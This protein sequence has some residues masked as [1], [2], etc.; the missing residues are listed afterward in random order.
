MRLVPS[1][2]GLREYGGLGE[3]MA[4]REPNA[5]QADAILH[6]GGALFVSAGAGSGKTYVLSRRAARLMLAAGGGSSAFDRVLVITFTEKA[7]GEILERI[8]R[9]LTEAR[10]SEAARAA[11]SAWV[12]TIHGFCLRVL[13]R[14]ALE[15]GVD[16]GFTVAAEEEAWALRRGAFEQAAREGLHSDQDL[17]RL[18]EDYGLDRAAPAFMKALEAVRAMGLAPGDV[19]LPSDPSTRGYAEAF[20]RLLAVY[21]EEYARAKRERAVVDYEDM[22]LLTARLFEGRPDIA[23]QYAKHFNEVM[24]DEFQ[25]TNA[26]QMRAVGPVAGE[27]LCTVGDECQAIY[28][29]RHADVGMF[30]SHREAAEVGGAHNSALSV[31][32]RSHPDILAFVNR[33]FSKSRLFGERFLQLQAGSDG[34]WKVPWAEGAPRVEVLV[35][36]REAGPHWRA[37]EAETLARRLREFVDAGANPGD[38]AILLRYGSCGDVYA[39]ALRRHGLNVSLGTG[40]PFFGRPEVADL[41]ALLRVMANP[42]DD[43]ALLRVLAGKPGGLSDSALVALRR[44]AG[45]D[46]L[47]KALR[48]PGAAGLDGIDGRQASRVR[49]VV[50]EGRRMTGSAGF[51]EAL[52][53]VVEQLDHDVALLAGPEGRIACSNALK[54][55]RMA[56]R[57]ERDETGG[58]L[59]F[60]EKLRQREALGAREKGAEAGEEDDAIRVM[61]V[62][63]AKGLEFPIVAVADMGHGSPRESDPFTVSRDREGRPALRMKVPGDRGRLVTGGEYDALQAVVDERDAEEE[64]RLLYVACTRA[65]EVLLLAGSAKLGKEPT[66]GTAIEAVLRELPQGWREGGRTELDGAALTVLLAP[67]LDT[68]PAPP[69][70]PRPDRAR[71]MASAEEPTADGGSKRE[72]ST[73]R[74]RTVSYTALRTHSLCPRRYELERTLGLRAY[75]PP[76]APGARELG[77]ALHS[78][79]QVSRPP[80]RPDAARVAAAAAL[81]GL[82]ASA[83]ERVSAAAGA[84]L[85]SELAARLHAHD[86]VSKEAPFAVPVSGSLLAGKMDAVGRT[87]ADWL[88]V[89]YKTGEGSGE[90]DDAYRMQAEC[91]ALAALVSG[92]ETVEVVFAEVETGRERAFTFVRDDEAGVRGWIETALDAMGGRDLADRGSFDEAACANCP[93]LR[94]MCSV[95][96]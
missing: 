27:A 11:G 81:G 17:E 12:S 77:D 9:E 6:E 56:S 76:G 31:N 21:D 23:E 61:T 86:V 53:H 24:I 14:H 87:G 41:R 75:A 47:W 3:V 34:G 51:A 68:P 85:N 96:R 43:E 69:A 28:G 37:A 5:G 84:F 38:I 46:P 1:L 35:A 93:A 82:D 4:T 33:L 90:D 8:R 59:G 95:R 89:D 20:S 48:D 83:A 44:S 30:R 72:S 94:G 66:G 71:E 25:D 73:E 91:Y 52:R 45:K 63:A 22:Q 74:P 19:V 16:P 39:D 58:I 55:L 92:A 49:R 32:Y 29:F 54:L 15:A 13:R 50:A 40:Q 26:L 62:H 10:D 70:R 80:G 65:E 42:L 2:R 78:V 67:P 7:A 79:L 60:L 88:V 57:Y 64:R 36:D 18:L